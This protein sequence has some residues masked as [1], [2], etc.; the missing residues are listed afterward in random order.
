[1]LERLIC[2]G[3]GVSFERLRRKRYGRIYCTTVCRNKNYGPRLKMP[4]A[5]FAK[6]DK[7]APGGCWLWTGSRLSVGY[8]N[9]RWGGRL[10]TTHRYAYEVAFGPI[11]EGLLVCHKCD[12]RACCNPEHLFLG[13]H[14]DNAADMMQK[15]RHVKATSGPRGSEIASSKLKEADVA[16]IKVQLR[17]KRS[18]PKIAKQYGVSVSTINAIAHGETW[19]QIA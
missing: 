10:V 13:T 9:F 1:M 19:R 17:A 8:G 16:E 4:D 6:L 3:C 7:T 11:P 15:G 2:D 14:A 18:Q 12:V 5:F